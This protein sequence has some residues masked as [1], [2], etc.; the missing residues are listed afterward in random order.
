[1]K[2]TN[3]SYI[4]RNLTTGQILGYY[5]ATESEIL[6]DDVDKYL[7]DNPYFK[8]EDL[9]VEIDRWGLYTPIPNKIPE[10]L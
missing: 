4:L 2:Q 9:G 3:A 5:A 10:W 1:M 8:E 7:R 6:E